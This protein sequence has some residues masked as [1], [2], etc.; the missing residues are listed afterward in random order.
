MRFS[1]Q[2]QTVID[3]F[4]KEKVFTKKSYPPNPDQRVFEELNPDEKER[5]ADIR[6]PSDI[7]SFV[8]T[9]LWEDDHELCLGTKINNVPIGLW[10]VALRKNKDALF[11]DPFYKKIASIPETSLNLTQQALIYGLL[12]G[13]Y[14]RFDARSEVEELRKSIDKI[15]A[16]Q[17]QHTSTHGVDLSQLEENNTPDLWFGIKR[18]LIDKAIYNSI[19]AWDEDSQILFKSSIEE[20]ENTQTLYGDLVSKLTENYLDDFI[21]RPRSEIPDPEYAADVYAKHEIDDQISEYLRPDDIIE[22]PNEGML[23]LIRAITLFSNG[24]WSI[25]SVFQEIKA[26][27][28]AQRQH[29]AT[30]GVDLTSLEEQTRVTAFDKLRDQV[31]ALLD[32]TNYEDFYKAVMNLPDLKITYN[33]VSVLKQLTLILD[34]LLGRPGGNGPAE[35]LQQAIVAINEIRSIKNSRRDSNPHV[36]HVDYLNRYAQNLFNEWLQSEEYAVRKAQQQHT[37]TH[38]VDLTS[39]EESKNYLSNK[40]LLDWLESLPAIKPF[41]EWFN[42][43]AG[44]KF[45]H[46]SGPL[47]WTLAALADFYLSNNY[48]TIGITGDK[49][50]ALRKERMRLAND[51]AKKSLKKLY[52]EFLL[53]DKYREWKAVQAAQQQHTSTHGVD[54]THLEESGNF[55][56]G[57]S[58]VI[59]WMKA[60]PAIEPFVEWL[61]QDSPDITSLEDIATSYYEDSIFEERRKM[62]GRGHDPL[63]RNA[64]LHQKAAQDAIEGLK[65]TYHYSGFGRSKIYQDWLAVRDAQQQ[66]TK[67]HGVDLSNLEEKY[68]SV[69][70]NTNSSYGIPDLTQ[71]VDDLVHTRDYNSFANIVKELFTGLPNNIPAHW[72]YDAAD[73]EEKI[74]KIIIETI[75]RIVD[76]EQ[77]GQKEDYKLKVDLVGLFWRALYSTMGKVHDRNPYYQSEEAFNEWRHKFEENKRIQAALRQHTKTH[78]VD[79]GDI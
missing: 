74:L 35:F 8:F 71:K 32:I 18:E 51:A 36:V 60:L 22:T 19:K 7:H 9:T 4:F 16:A 52:D 45:L 30:H 37:G 15:R 34:D 64:E 1:K 10:W 66:H 13:Q 28:N 75:H 5:I 46:T 69:L 58:Q 41:L 39:L 55:E 79:L 14:D 21:D 59:D 11:K 31:K 27:K 40:V 77:A 42:K 72:L 17:Q 70:E 50:D 25:D 49:N 68:K 6:S 44:P 47:E 63:T 53:S 33:G 61:S 65:N 23:P 24:E 20:Y 62:Y 38:G 78:G 56:Q 2:Y 57:L 3:G 73:P 67:T 54:L 12:D 48:L 29:T 26:I 43:T 76:A